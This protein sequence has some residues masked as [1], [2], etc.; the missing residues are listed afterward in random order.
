[1]IHE[2]PF[3]Q[4]DALALASL[5]DRETPL[6]QFQK[7]TISLGGTLGRFTITKCGLHDEMK[8]KQLYSIIVLSN[9]FCPF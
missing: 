7:H 6:D 2:L 5:R 1:M 8:K 9:D 4:T 3:S